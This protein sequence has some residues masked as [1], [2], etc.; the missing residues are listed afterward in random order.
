MS[1]QQQAALAKLRELQAAGFPQRTKLGGIITG[2]NTTTLHNL[3]AA[4]FIKCSAVW[5]RGVCSADLIV[6]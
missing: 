5:L 4:G 1:K 6:K 3:G 2:I